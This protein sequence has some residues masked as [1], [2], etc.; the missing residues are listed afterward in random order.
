MHGN[1]LFGSSETY[2]KYP[3]TDNFNNVERVV[4][5]APYA[6]V[7]VVRVRGHRVVTGTQEFSLVATGN[8]V[9]QHTCKW[10]YCPGNCSGH[11][12]CQNGACTCDITYFGPDCSVHMP[13]LKPGV[14]QPVAV[15]SARWSFYAFY[16][17]TAITSWTLSFRG[18]SLP[19]EM[20]QC[21]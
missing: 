4:I 1:E 7:Y 21:A 11:G 20:N 16:V 15:S 3:E 19:E 10:P 14:A 18:E 17:D 6:G 8:F 13:R 12:T 5:P 2:S 9:T